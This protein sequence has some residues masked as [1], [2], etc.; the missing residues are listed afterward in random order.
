MIID[1]LQAKTTLKCEEAF[2][3][4]RENCP[5]SHKITDAQLKKIITESEGL[6]PIITLEVTA[7][8]HQLRT[9]GRASLRTIILTDDFTD[10]DL[11]TYLLSA[12]WDP[13]IASRQI[14]QDFPL[15]EREHQCRKFL[16]TYSGRGL[17]REY[18]IGLLG[19][20][21]GDIHRLEK[22]FLKGDLAKRLDGF[23]GLEEGDLEGLLKD[24]KWRVLEAA[25][26]FLIGKL[27]EFGA[28][29]HFLSEEQGRH[30]LS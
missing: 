19:E 23:E 11:D 8:L 10:S 12:C 28:E 18:L 2:T 21:E 22:H 15:L 17:T 9:T 6:L 5:D 26:N 29:H 27:V 13:N 3:T 25:E 1:D 4:T 30:F 7:T 16:Q 14:F 20:Y 24:A